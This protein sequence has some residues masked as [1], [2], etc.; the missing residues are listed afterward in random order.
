MMS[1]DFKEGAG[2]R[3]KLTA[4]CGLETLAAA[5]IL[6]GL[7]SARAEV[8][9]AQT[10][11]RFSADKPQLLVTAEYMTVDELTEPSLMALLRKYDIL[12]APCIR[13]YQLETE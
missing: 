11:L 7:G 1:A 6:L 12:V 2:M 10:P 13:D 3:K 8:P 5:G 4:R 9:Q